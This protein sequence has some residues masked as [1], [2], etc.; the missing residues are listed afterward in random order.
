MK[1]STKVA[2]NTIIQVISKIFATILGL[3]A[4]AIIT[5]YLGQ[6]GFGE[7]TTVVTFLSF[8]AILADLGLT[9]VTVQMI[10]R[11]NIDQNKILGNLLAL[12]LVSAV[13]FLAF[14]PLVAIFFPYS[15]IIKIGIAITTL[16]FLVRGKRLT[17]SLK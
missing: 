3:I 9:L 4:V 5:R 13:I 14:A 1:L 6:V 17:I 11:P 10:S 8:F 15:N 12:R 2:Y 7:Y 16:N